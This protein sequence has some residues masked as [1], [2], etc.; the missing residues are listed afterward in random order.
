LVEE[1]LAMDGVTA[2]LA[3][4]PSSTSFRSR[5][6]NNANERHRLLEAAESN[7]P[8]A[9]RIANRQYLDFDSKKNRVKKTL[10]GWRVTINSWVNFVEEVLGRTADH[11][12]HGLCYFSRDGPLPDRVLLRKY[13]LWY[14]ITSK[15][16]RIEKVILDGINPIRTP[17][18]V[19]TVEAR[20]SCLSSCF[21]YYN[22]SLPKEL[23][24]D[25]R[26]YVS[27]EL[28][29]EQSLNTGMLSKPLAYEQDA[30]LLIQKFFC[31]QLQWL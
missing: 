13:L 23:A 8:D 5:Q 18:A 19:R 17:L 11:P 22:R 31:P 26:S 7:K 9:E 20:L 27:S 25:T 29:K 24:R 28:A 3:S 14:C 10:K 6:A 12:E 15:G 2:L 4:G 21:S 1:A 16:G 30:D